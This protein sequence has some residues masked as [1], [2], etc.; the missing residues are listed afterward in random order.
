[1]GEKSRQAHQG[2]ILSI[3]AYLYPKR[4]EN[5]GRQQYNVQDFTA[6]PKLTRK[7][8]EHVFEKWCHT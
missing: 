2:K 8:P 1:M 5:E 3:P 4:I 6:A 7:L